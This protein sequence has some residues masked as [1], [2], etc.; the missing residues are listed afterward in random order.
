MPNKI[1]R[2]ANTVV[3]LKRNFQKLTHLF[4]GGGLVPVVAEE[5]AGSAEAKMGV[6]TLVAGTVT[7]ATEAVTAISR[8][9][10][11]GQNSSG[12]AGELTVSARVAG[13]SFDIT[14]TDAGD[15]RDVA[16]II[17]EPAAQ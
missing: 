11:T 3:R 16:W 15:T 17:F 2:N 14:S 10:L 4:F 5:P 1:D 6:A 7:V 9:M 8:I 13:T 12:T